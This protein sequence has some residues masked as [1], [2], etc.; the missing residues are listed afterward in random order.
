[1]APGDGLL[2]LAGVGQIAGHD[3]RLA[4]AALDLLR[5]RLDRCRIAPD[6]HEAAAFA[7]ECLGDDGTHS[8]GRSSDDRNAALEHQVHGVPGRLKK[9]EA[10]AVANVLLCDP[11]SLLKDSRACGRSQEP[12]EF[13][14]ARL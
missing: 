4:A 2:A 3:D 10:I 1:M 5:D 11:A 6:E 7:C 8:L 9:E 14:G 12:D 13:L